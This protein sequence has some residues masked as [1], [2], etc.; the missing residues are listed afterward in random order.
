MK[1]LA[2]LQQTP[3][4]EAAFARAVEEA[5]K[6]DAEL[7][8]VAF[9]HSPTGEE[10][11]RSYE[12]ERKTARQAAEQVAAPLRESGMT[13]GVHVPVGVTKPSQALLRVASQ[14]HADLLVIGVR[15]R[16][17]VGKLVLGSNAQ[18]I[19]LQADAPVLAVK[20]D[21]GDG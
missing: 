15:R 17:R 2:G 3:E 5:R 14:E 10:S 13:V 4:G 6:H 16:S 9:V 11:G 18:D 12:R 1:I 8:L 19:I 21:D 20:A 7:V